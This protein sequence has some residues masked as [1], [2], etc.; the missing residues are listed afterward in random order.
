MMCASYPEALIWSED[1]TGV[2][3]VTGTF[4]LKPTSKQLADK[5]DI[6]KD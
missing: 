1:R 2:S 5:L 4:I 6:T 3:V